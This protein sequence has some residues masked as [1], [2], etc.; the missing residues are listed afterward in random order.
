MLNSHLVFINNILFIL[1]VLDLIGYEFIKW[2][3]GIIINLLL[4]FSLYLILVPFIPT[5]KTK[6]VKVIPG[7]AIHSRIMDAS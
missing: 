2:V 1:A 3:I 4:V 6:M 5:P 7:K